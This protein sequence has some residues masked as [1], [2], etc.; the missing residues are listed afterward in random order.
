MKFEAV[1]FDLGGTLIEYENHNWDELGRMGCKAA[2]PLLSN[3]GLEAVTPE[4]LWNDFH[5][6]IDQMFINHSEDLKEIDLY[7]VTSIILSNFGISN[8]DGLV[9]KFVDAYYQPITNQ[10]SLIQG[11][12]EI[13]SKCHAAGLKIGLVSN[14]IF[15]ARFHRAEMERFGILRF[16]DFTIFSSEIKIRKPK[17]EIFLKALELACTKP[18]VSVFVGDRLVEDVG[19]PQSVGIN[20][21]L[22]FVDDR[23][24]SAPIKPYGIIHS[25]VELEKIIL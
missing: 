12:Y 14:T 2:Y 17:R 3:L 20:G 9:A 16:F 7:Q 4:R 5:Y 25:L 11:V 13:L 1:I 22:K 18:E 10:V 6:A 24:Y 21:I 8:P 23:D 15:P 19:G